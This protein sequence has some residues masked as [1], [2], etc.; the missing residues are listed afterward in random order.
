MAKAGTIQ[1]I[2]QRQQDRIIAQSS[3]AIFMNPYIQI[4]DE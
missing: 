2:K 1:A 3:K 4:S